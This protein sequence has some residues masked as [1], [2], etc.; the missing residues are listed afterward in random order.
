M[1]TKGQWA[2]GNEELSSHWAVAVG[3]EGIG[4]LG[5]T[6]EKFTISIIMSL[7]GKN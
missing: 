4:G 6:T 3:V 2:P 7:H 1:E 5:K